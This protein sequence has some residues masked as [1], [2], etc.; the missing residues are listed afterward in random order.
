[1]S[2]FCE[3]LFPIILSWVFLPKAI[4]TEQLRMVR[5]ETNLVDSLSRLDF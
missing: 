1:M 3:A 2:R 4:E 5:S